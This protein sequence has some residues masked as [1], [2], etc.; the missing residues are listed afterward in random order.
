MQTRPQSLLAQLYRDET[1]AEGLEKILIIAAIVL[2]LLGLL[3][4]FRN[5]IS[6]WVTDNW[7]TVKTDADTTNIATPN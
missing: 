2:P 1:G 7:N 4:I 3:I 5:K 6:E